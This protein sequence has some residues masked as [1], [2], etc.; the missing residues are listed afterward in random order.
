MNGQLSWLMGRLFFVSYAILDTGIFI[1]IKDVKETM[2]T[3][4]ELSTVTKP[5]A[6]TDR[7]REKK[8]L[9]IQILLVTLVV[10]VWGGLLYGGY[11]L[12]NQYIQ[13]TRLY[14]DQQ[15]NE[16]KQQNQQQVTLLQTE[17]LKVHEELGL[18]K[19]ELAFADETLNGSNQTKTALQ[20]RM[21]LLDSQLNQLK[22]SLKQLE[23]AARV[24]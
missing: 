4:T 22:T 8:R 11:Y 2:E 1:G 13:E 16:I 3:I 14:V 23:E 7:R 15:L 10:A 18:I 20:E 19:E 5:S 24:H 17:L 12:A 21:A 9:A 6:A